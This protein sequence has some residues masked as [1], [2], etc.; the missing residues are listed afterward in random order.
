MT[1]SDKLGP[2]T[3][4]E[5]QAV[6]ELAKAWADED[7]TGTYDFDGLVCAAIAAVQLRYLGKLTRLPDTGPEA[8]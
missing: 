3:L 5:A 6:L 8:S 1:E 7:F 2:L 4:A